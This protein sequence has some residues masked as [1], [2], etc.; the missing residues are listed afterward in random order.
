LPE[1]SLGNVEAER[2]R[3]LALSSIER[4]KGEMIDMGP[5]K[6]SA[7]EVPQIRPLQPASA[8]DL[9]DLWCQAPTG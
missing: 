2:P 7:G 3:D 8:Q 6:E 9:I 5:Q 4:Q 1:P